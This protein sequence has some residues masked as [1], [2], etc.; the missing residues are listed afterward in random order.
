M[1]PL[2]IPF[3]IILCVLFVLNQ[4]IPLFEL[5]CFVGLLLLSHC[6][7][8]FCDLLV[9]DTQLITNLMR[10]VLSTYV[11]PM[12]GLFAK[13]NPLFLR[14]LTSPRQTLWLK[15]WFRLN[16]VCAGE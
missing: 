6:Q 4:T 11:V 12:L 9:G 5:E 2:G 1:N 15:Q 14:Y 8:F 7:Q 16:P 3:A 13:D 10:Q